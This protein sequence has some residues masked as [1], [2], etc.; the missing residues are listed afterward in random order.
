MKRLLKILLT[1]GF[2]MGLSTT[3][4]FA[5]PLE[6]KQAV[7]VY[8]ILSEN[9]IGGLQY[10]YRFNNLIST[11]VD[12]F[13]YYDGKYR[14]ALNYNGNIELD[15]TMDESMWK[16]RYSSRLYAYILAGH[17]GN[18]YFGE[19][20][21]QQYDAV[22]SAGFGFDFTLFDHLSI[23]I[24]FGFLGTFPDNKSAGF[25]VGSGIRYSF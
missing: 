13:M 3:A 1:F 5:N 17:T 10:E 18:L 22:L 9:P 24:Q 11:K 8:Y 2:L 4:A 14:E 21:H 25:C 16:E 20:P 15:I 12:V 6:N 7:G 19:T 23:P